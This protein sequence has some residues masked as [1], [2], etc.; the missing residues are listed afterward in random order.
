M[1]CITTNANTHGRSATSKLDKTGRK[2]LRFYGTRDMLAIAIQL[3][4]KI[5]ALAVAHPI[6]AG[7]L[8]LNMTITHS[9]IFSTQAQH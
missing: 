3:F 7:T 1:C 6:R 2:T 5:F 4:P 8:T 9:F